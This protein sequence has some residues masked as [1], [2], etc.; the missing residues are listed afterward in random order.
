MNYP[1]VF[2]KETI[3]F[4]ISDHFLDHFQLA[5]LNKESKG[6]ERLAKLVHNE[7]QNPKLTSN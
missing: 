7:Q 4:I 3:A 1:F 6:K 2:L 5:F